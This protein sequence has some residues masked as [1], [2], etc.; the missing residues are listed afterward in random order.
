MRAPRHAARNL[1]ETK[2]ISLDLL[3]LRY[4]AQGGSTGVLEFNAYIHG[5]LQPEQF[6]LKLIDWALEE[7]LPGES[8]D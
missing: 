3:W 2:T 7:A 8:Q 6:E 5:A 4:W 1:L